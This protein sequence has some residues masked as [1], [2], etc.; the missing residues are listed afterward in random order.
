MGSGVGTSKKNLREFQIVV[1][2]MLVNRVALVTGAAG[3][4]GKAVAERFAR[5]GAKV[6]VADFDADK[7]KETVDSINAR[8]GRATF[9]LTDVTD[10]ASVEA[11]FQ[12]CKEKYDRLDVLVNNAV[13]FTFGHLA[14]EGSGSGTVRCSECLPLSLCC[15]ADR[16]C[17]VNSSSTS[18]PGNGPQHN[19]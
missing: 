13:K 14:G 11:A 18:P 4:I 19:S 2:T 3:G 16:P 15:L 9:A 7:G 8:G 17:P 6:V 10:H 5:E 12:S 1:W